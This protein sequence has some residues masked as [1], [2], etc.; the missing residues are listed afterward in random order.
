M[1]NRIKKF[2]QSRLRANH[3]QAIVNVIIRYIKIKRLIFPYQADKF[4]NTIESQKLWPERWVKMGDPDYSSKG[5]GFVDRINPALGDYSKIKNVL[6]N[7]CA[8]KNT[9]EIGCLDGKWSEVVIKNSLSLILVDLTDALLPLLK[10]KFGSKISFYKTS[11]NELTG[12]PSN[13]ID[14][15]FSI[16]SLV[17]VPDKSYISDYLSD[18]KRVLTQGGEIFIHLPCHEIE[19]SKIRGFTKL[20][21]KDISSFCSE[22]NLKVIDLNTKIL[23]HG[24]LLSAVKV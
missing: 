10:K 7:K 23:E 8:N 13:S 9:L 16:D 11:G 5:W 3:Y 20:S 14:L 18:F 17:R 21:I 19:G 4:N 12:I 2:L 6:E 22:N 1:K 24:V 15:I